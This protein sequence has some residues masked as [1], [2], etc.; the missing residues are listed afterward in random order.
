MQA[1]TRVGLLIG[2]S[3]TGGNGAGLA[4]WL[5]QLLEDRLNAPG[6]AHPVELVPVDPR[7]APHPLGPVV[8]GARLPSQVPDAAGYGAPGVRAWSRLAAGCAGLAVLSPEYNGGYPGELKNA[9]DH[10]YREWAAKPVLLVTYGGGGGL[11]CQAQLRG[12]LEALRMRVVPE[13]VGIRL[14]A[15]YTGGSERVSPA[16]AHGFPGFLEPYVGAVHG[17][18][19]RLREMLLEKPAGSQWCAASRRIAARM[20]TADMACSDA[21]RCI[22]IA[23]YSGHMHASRLLASSS[24]AQYT[25]CQ[26]STKA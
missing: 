6:A 4:V 16:P 7:V 5:R 25:D 12:V 13:P 8:D 10:L 2:S 14:P 9:L 26:D 24:T 3:R 11:R 20:L 17:G 18:A 21:R 1:A 22:P 15:A 19:D 23:L